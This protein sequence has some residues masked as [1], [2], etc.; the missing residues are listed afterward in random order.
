MIYRFLTPEKTD[1][2]MILEVF[3]ETENESN[4][5]EYVKNLLIN[6][7]LKMKQIIK[8]TTKG[9]FGETGVEI[10]KKIIKG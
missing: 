1:K 7:E 10:V 6:H 2:P 5:L 8:N 3:T 9:I 4:T